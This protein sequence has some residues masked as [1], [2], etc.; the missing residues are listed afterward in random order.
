MVFPRRA[1]MLG[2]SVLLAAGVTGCGDDPPRS[3]TTP[4]ASAAPSA[5]SAPG[6]PPGEKLKVTSAEWIG[7]R[8]INVKSE[9]GGYTHYANGIIVK[10]T[11]GP[12]WGER[13][14]DGGLLH[15]WFLVFRSAAVKSKVVSPPSCAVPIDGHPDYC[16]DSGARY[17]IS[18]GAP[19]AVN[20][21]YRPA[22]I[23]LYDAGRTTDIT[24]EGR[25]FHAGD[26]FE[27]VMTGPSAPDRLAKG[28]KSGDVAVIWVDPKRAGE[29]GSLDIG[30][31]GSMPADLL[32]PLNR[33]PHDKAIPPIQTGLDRN[34][35]PYG[36]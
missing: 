29:A 8:P 3:P 14:Y 30:T 7:T 19:G 23:Y 27:I 13:T 20:A 25:Q 32:L 17:G 26:G 10:G 16:F 12:G 15:G 35:K 18:F 1:H 24:S 36:S 11:V 28:L 6:A 21:I 2:L 4:A 33:L 31:T 22:R 34:S 9:A 5:P